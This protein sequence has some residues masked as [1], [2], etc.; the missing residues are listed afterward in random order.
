MYILFLGKIF[1]RS[2]DGNI[3]LYIVQLNKDEKLLCR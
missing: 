2:N 3:Y 1:L